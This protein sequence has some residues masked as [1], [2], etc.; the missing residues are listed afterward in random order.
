[1][2]I[3]AD[4][5]RWVRDRPSHSNLSSQP[6]AAQTVAERFAVLKAR[7]IQAN[8]DRIAIECNSCCGDTWH[9]LLYKHS[10]KIPVIEEEQTGPEEFEQSTIGH[11]EERWELFQ[12][13]GCDSLTVRIGKEDFDDG[14]TYLTF[15]PDRL[16]WQRKS[17]DYRTIPSHIHKIY[18]EVVTAFN[19]GMPM[20]C[21]GGLRALL[22]GICK[23]KGIDKG[24]TKSG[25]VRD[26]L[27]GK[28]NGLVKIVPQN[29]TQNLHSVRFF[30]NK[31]LHELGVP[32]RDELDLALTVMEDIM[33][34]VYD[35]DYQAD[36]LNRKAVR[37][38]KTLRARKKG[39]GARALTHKK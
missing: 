36:L 23:D 37:Y 38:R 19:R 34:V 26:T 16:S 39:R 8:E 20:L 17:R 4:E 1:M 25:K 6:L 10:I 2:L 29:I 3:L 11:V 13:L 28:I 14:R 32:E 21:A 9:R 5:A 12:C 24:M 27:E 31:A 15:L 7:K 30:G 35:L 33:N 22:E 18:A